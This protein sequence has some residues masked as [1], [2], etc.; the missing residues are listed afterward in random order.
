VKKSRK[1]EM[2][3]KNPRGLLPSRA[4]FSNHLQRKG[5]T[6]SKAMLAPDDWFKGS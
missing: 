4:V 3:A 5:A 6:S 2:K 1:D